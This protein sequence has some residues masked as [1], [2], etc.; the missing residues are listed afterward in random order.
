[1]K[2]TANTPILHDGERYEEGDPIELTDKDAK[3][4]GAKVTPAK[5]AKEEKK[6]T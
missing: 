5:P 6:P 2:Y 3:R 4:L 1:M